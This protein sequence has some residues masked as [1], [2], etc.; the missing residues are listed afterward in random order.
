MDRLTHRENL[1]GAVPTK[2]DLQLC[3]DL[4][5]K[6]W[7]SLIEIIDRLAAYE[8]IG[9]TPE[10]ITERM[11]IFKECHLEVLKSYLYTHTQESPEEVAKALTEMS[12]RLGNN[13]LTLTEL[14]A[15]QE[16][17]VW[18]QDLNEGT[19]ESCWAIVGEVWKDNKGIDFHDKFC[20]SGCTDCGAFV[21]YGKTWLA[22]R[23]E[24][25]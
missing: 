25:E 20:S 15:M 9:L 23:R 7:D 19:N 24:V 10:E 2:L 14:K 5:D 4:P 11:E 12:T 18:I 8:D 13:P 6:Q 22:Y 16:K 17:P 1:A 3:I 21:F